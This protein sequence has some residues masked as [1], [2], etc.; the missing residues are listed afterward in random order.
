M[1]CLIAP[2]VRGT[3]VAEKAGR[4]TTKQLF[5]NGVQKIE[6]QFFPQNARV[7]GLVRKLGARLEGIITKSSSIEGVLTDVEIWGL[8]PEGAKEA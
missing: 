2:H 8:Y 4:I 1:H 3:D 7:R 6:F 5:S